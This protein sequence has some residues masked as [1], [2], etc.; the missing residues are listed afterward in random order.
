MR[1]GKAT[2]LEETTLVLN[3]KA[4]ALFLGSVLAVAT[5][6]AFAFNN[7]AEDEYRKGSDFARKGKD[8]EA[9]QALDKSITLN[10]NYAP[11]YLERAR[12]LNRCSR[13]KEALESCNKC[14]TI[15]PEYGA[16]YS[17]RSW[18]HVALKEYSAA[19]E[20]ANKAMALAS[21]PGTYVSRANAYL[22]LGQLKQALADCNKAVALKRH[23]EAFHTRARIWIALGEYKNA[24]NDCTSAIDMYSQAPLYYKT[25]AF[26]YTKMGDTSSASKDREKYKSLE[27]VENN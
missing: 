2:K 19:I 23:P 13:A 21:S 26:A 1:K 7:A 10:P 18:A 6:S 15:N 20:D 11:A 3:R 22:G 16:A 9:L 14:L 12:V 17:I 5:T 25:R 8:R 4:T 27:K 24:V